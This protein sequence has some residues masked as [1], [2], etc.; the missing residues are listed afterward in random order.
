MADNISLSTAFKIFR[1][2]SDR[3]IKIYHTFKNYIFRP[4]P[5]IIFKNQV[6]HFKEDQVLLNVSYPSIIISFRKT[7][8]IDLEKTKINK[9]SLKVLISKDP[10]YTNLTK[11]GSKKLNI[12]NCKLYE[13]FASN[14][15]IPAENGYLITLNKFENLVIPLYLKNSSSNCL[16][17]KD[18]FVPLLLPYQKLHLKL[19]I[20]GYPYYYGIKHVE[21]FKVIINNLAFNR[22]E[23][24]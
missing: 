21:A 17:N 6:L 3:F 7:A 22:N 14:D 1:F 10:N 18:K 2:L 13:V 19:E 20:N 5:K 23:N 24:I 9:E 11:R 16:F 12:Q 4:K 15:S 8:Q